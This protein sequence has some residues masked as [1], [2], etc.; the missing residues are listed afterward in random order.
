MMVLMD[1]ER[2]VKELVD[3][4]QKASEILESFGFDFWSSW[5]RRDGLRIERFDV[6]ALDHL[7]SAFGG[8]GSINDV[9]IDDTSLSGE[10]DPN[11]Q[12]G[13]HLGAIYRL[14]SSLLPEARHL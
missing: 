13:F 9:R 5:L 12:L 7:L 2:G 4:V 14:A 6:T 11:T 1:E 8:M 10:Q 3:H